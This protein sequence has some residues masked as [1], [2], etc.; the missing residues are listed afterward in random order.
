MGYKSNISFD[1]Q[2]TLNN[3]TDLITAVV[4]A[5]LGLNEIER[6]T[7]RGWNQPFRPVPEIQLTIQIS[8]CNTINHSDQCLQYN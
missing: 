2:A 6:F 1:G 7:G 4:V 5:L 8:A 3:P